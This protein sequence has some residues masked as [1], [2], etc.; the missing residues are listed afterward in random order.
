MTEFVL[1]PKEPTEEMLAAGFARSRRTCGGI[2]EAMLSASPT[3]PEAQV[4]SVREALENLST[5]WERRVTAIG[6][7]CGSYKECAKDLR[8]LI[9]SIEQ[10]EG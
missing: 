3:P 2:W 5:E 6:R 9:P 7:D 1:V 10:R 4:E 8:A